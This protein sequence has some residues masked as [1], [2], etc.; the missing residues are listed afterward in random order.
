MSES[1]NSAPKPASESKL[2]SGRFFFLE[3]SGGQ[4]HSMSPDGSMHKVIVTGCRLPVGIAVDASAGHIYWTNMGIPSANDGSIERADLD[5]KNRTTIVYPGDTHTPRQLHLDHINRKLYWCDCGG[6]R[7]MR[8]NFDGSELETLIET[9]EGET[10]SVDQAGWCMGIT[11]DHTRGQ[12]YWTQKGPAGTG[13][14]RIFR[15]NIDI[16]KGETPAHRSDIEIWL[17]GLPKPIELQ[18]DHL[19]RILY[20]TA[21]EGRRRGTVNRA[22]IDAP[23]RR[24]KSE[25][26]FTHL[27]E[28]IGISLDLPGERMFLTDLGGCVYSADLSGSEVRILFYA[29]GQLTGIAYG[30]PP[31]NEIDHSA[32]EISPAEVSARAVRADCG[33][34]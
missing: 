3:A 23:A 10:N 15:S 33:V 30:E 25:T 27:V 7:I 21:K 14:G 19:N 26:V 29:Q 8:S 5:G 6:T 20:W 17:D 13:L 16:P 24:R 22:E 34:D 11:L 2:A 4:I 32:R 18:F 12:I 9:G 1:L 31:R 28:G